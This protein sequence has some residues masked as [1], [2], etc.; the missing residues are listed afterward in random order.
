MS[1]HPG[2]RPRPGGRAKEM[3]VDR[4]YVLPLDERT[5]REGSTGALFSR[6]AS[7]I[8]NRAVQVT[9]KPQAGLVMG[10][11]KMGDSSP[12]SFSG[13]KPLEKDLMVPQFV[14]CFF[15]KLDRASMADPYM[16]QITTQTA[17]VTGNQQQSCQ[18]VQ[19][20][21]KR[22]W[23][24]VFQMCYAVTHRAGPHPS[25]SWLETNL[26]QGRHQLRNGF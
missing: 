7:Q 3:C 11:R 10:E 23:D 4:T 15:G 1:R 2:T 26:V 19:K 16:Q 6:P 24:S 22:E 25:P 8:H 12:L 9:H 17:D 14:A 21:Q 5:G 18:S 20:T 13:K